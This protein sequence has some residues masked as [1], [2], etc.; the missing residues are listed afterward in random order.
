MSRQERG[1]GLGER[2]AFTNSTG[3]ENTSP[4]PSGITPPREARIVYRD[5]EARSIAERAGIMPQLKALCSEVGCVAVA[6]GTANAEFV[7]V[8]RFLGFQE[9]CENGYIAYV[10]T[11]QNDRD[12]FAHEVMSSARESAQA[13]SG[14][15]RDSHE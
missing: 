3:S 1:R 13:Q 4:L 15:G 2:A 11:N 12:R 7:A 14:E 8:V 5:S 9:A 6:L 10:A